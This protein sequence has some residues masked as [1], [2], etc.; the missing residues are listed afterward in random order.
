MT[1]LTQDQRDNLRIGIG[2][3]R[4]LAENR[5]AAA[6]ADDLLDAVGD[7]ERLAE[8]E[9]IDAL[10]IC[11]KHRLY[12]RTVAARYRAKSMEPQARGMDYQDNTVERIEAVLLGKLPALEA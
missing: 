9:S 4:A 12:Y 10:A 1:N 3:M 8:L 11:H 7:S 6:F 5:E 2:V